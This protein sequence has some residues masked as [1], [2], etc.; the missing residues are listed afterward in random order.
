MPV[1]F[2]PLP[3]IRFEISEAAHI[4][5]ISRATLYER[6]TA[7][8]LKAHKDGRRSFI[9]AARTAPVCG[10]QGLE[11]AA[12][13]PNVAQRC[14]DI[15]AWSRAFM[16]A[17]GPHPTTRLV[18]AGHRQ[19]M[20][21]DGSGC[22][23]GVRRLAI[24]TG[25]DKNTVAKHR[26]LALAAGWLIVAGQPSSLR[27]RTYLAAVPEG[28]AIPQPAREAARTNT[29]RL[30]ESTGHSAPARLSTFASATVP[31]IHTDRL[32]PRDKTLVLTN[33]RTLPPDASVVSTSPGAGCLAGITPHLSGG[34]PTGDGT[35]ALV[36]RLRRWL[37][38]D[39]MAERYQGCYDVLIGITPT[40][41]R[42]QGYKEV[43]RENRGETANPPD[44]GGRRA[45]YRR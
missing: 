34:A 39:G 5:R 8:K 28:L 38:T 40:E 35:E 44:E 7:G 30:S 22:W 21:R 3:Q 24:V 23:A 29:P 33:N 16:S 9:T 26:S 31:P 2:D 1:S 41:L 32:K 25:L 4:L 15:A 42:F 6:I 37:R 19:F 11:K 36:D 13:N 10:R 14:E 43:I 27:Y 12:G 45:R 18:L 17:S 20:K